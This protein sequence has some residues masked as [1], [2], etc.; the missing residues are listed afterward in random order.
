ML[1]S[2][3]SSISVH[4]TSSLTGPDVTLDRWCYVALVVHEARVEVRSFIWVWRNN[5][6][7]TTRERIFQEME[8]GE[9]FAFGHEQVVS[10]ES[11]YY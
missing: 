5:M 9:E 2:D 3:L 4:T 7:A 8:H 10:E 6:G 1:V 11:V